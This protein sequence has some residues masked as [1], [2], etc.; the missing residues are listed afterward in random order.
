M[1]YVET[2]KLKRYKDRIVL[3]QN[4]KK[5]VKLGFLINIKK[6]RGRGE[7]AG[8]GRGGDGEESGKEGWVG[9]GE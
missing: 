4:V 6:G 9:R 2:V 7:M 5:R 8:D 3:E 1:K